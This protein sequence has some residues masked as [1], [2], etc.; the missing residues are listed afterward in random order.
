[1]GIHYVCI[2]P[3]TEGV[4]ERSKLGHPD[5][6]DEKFWKYKG[7]LG[8][9]GQL[10]EPYGTDRGV[11]NDSDTD[12][13]SYD[14]DNPKKGVTITDTV[15]DDEE[16][17]ELE[18]RP[19]VDSSDEEASHTVDSSDG[20]TNEDNASNDIVQRNTERLKRLLGNDYSTFIAIRASYGWNGSTI[21]ERLVAATAHLLPRT[22]T[23][24]KVNHQ[25]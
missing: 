15:S 14:H 13:T 19:T 6:G 4:Y 8:N 20:E 21:H 9:R 11:G 5:T 24:R 17:P 23:T 22:M 2:Q 1:M 7:T 18:P 16:P 25:P 3:M 10:I 12:T